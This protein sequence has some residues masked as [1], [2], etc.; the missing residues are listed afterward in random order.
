MGRKQTIAK[1][2]SDRS[3]IA[4]RVPGS[5]VGGPASGFETGWELI[6]EQV[7]ADID[8]YRDT[9]DP[10]ALAHR[11]V[12]LS[13]LEK[14]SSLVRLFLIVE[15]VDRWKLDT[16]PWVY[17]TTYTGLKVSS[18]KQYYACGKTFLELREKLPQI[19]FNKFVDKA[20]SE[21]IRVAQHYRE[22]NP[23]LEEMEVIANTEPGMLKSALDAQAERTSSRLVLMED[24]G[25]K[26]WAHRVGDEPAVVALL[27]IGSTNRNVNAALERLRRT[28]GIISK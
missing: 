22:H 7:K 5:S 24:E 6:S 1:N 2:E 11:V 3:A 18:L 23:T 28:A 10:G 12:Q 21:Q 13:Q 19:I 27:K 15:V 25:G 26:V 17:L 9:G 16:D 20:L 4:R 8:V 14:F